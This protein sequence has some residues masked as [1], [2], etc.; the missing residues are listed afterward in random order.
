MISYVPSTAPNVV[1]T[2]NNF[3]IH[4]HPLPTLN[5]NPLLLCQFSCDTIL[6]KKKQLEE[7][8]IEPI[9]E[10]ELRVLW[11]LVFSNMLLLI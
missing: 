11:S 3:K 10:F 5:N 6:L 9:V 2:L 7:M 4:L 1:P 8:L